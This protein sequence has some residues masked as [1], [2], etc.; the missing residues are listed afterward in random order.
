MRYLLPTA[1]A[2]GID[3]RLWSL[4]GLRYSPVSELGYLIYVVVVLY[5]HESEMFCEVVIIVVVSINNIL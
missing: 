1:M 2:A 5:I 3:A 4:I